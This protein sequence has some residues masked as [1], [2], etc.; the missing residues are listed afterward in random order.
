MSENY[1]LSIRD[2]FTESLL[3]Q[4]LA[5][6]LLFLLIISQEWSDIF[7]LLYPL[8]LFFFSVFFKIISTNREK[9]FFKN[10]PIVFYP[11]GSEN[12][13]ANRL[14]F[15][16]LILLILIFWIG[17]ESYYHP[18]LI[19]N[20]NFLYIIVFVFVYTFGYFWIFID[21]WK[22]CQFLIQFPEK[23][24]P[25]PELAESITKGKRNYIV[26]S[27]KLNKFKFISITNLIVFLLLN[28]I[29]LLL[30]LFIS[31]SSLFSVALTLPGTGIE[32]S[33]PLYFSIVIYP[34]FIISPLI[35][36]IFLYLIYKD[37]MDI[38][39]I[40]LKQLL[41][42]LPKKEE[43]I[44]RENLSILVTKRNKNSKTE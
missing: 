24:N 3:R 15:S 39:E 21:I 7:I 37:M 23:N 13:H 10:S 42:E 22:N 25:P 41:K 5:F 19:N 18:Q 26:S 30:T 35:M 12:K 17:A 33:E 29:N 27:L 43:I 16:S 2:L 31:K 14:F 36:S 40:E 8:S 34:I 38:N 4:L 9:N 44:L 11:I 28:I 20:Y 32:S 6:C 1:Y